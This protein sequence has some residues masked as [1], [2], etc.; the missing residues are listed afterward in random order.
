[1]IFLCYGRSNSSHCY[2]MPPF[3][4]GTWT[5][6]PFLLCLVPRTFPLSERFCYCYHWLYSFFGRRDFCICRI[7]NVRSSS[8]LLGCTCH[9]CDIFVDPCP[10]PSMCLLDK[11]VWN[12]I[13][14]RHT[15]ILYIHILLLGIVS[16]SY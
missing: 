9:I 7:S 10:L 12:G 13:S 16:L 8:L 6:I 3:F 4:P 11:S 1:M 14:E 15:S 2:T 5:P